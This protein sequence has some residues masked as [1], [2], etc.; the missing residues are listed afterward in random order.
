MLGVKFTETMRGTFKRPGEAAERAIEFTITARGSALRPRF[1]AD[2]TLSAE[3]IATRRP[4]HGQLILRPILG[5]TLR[6]ELEFT[7][8]DGRPYGFAGQKDLELLRLRKTMTTLPGQIR[9][10]DG[11]VVGEVVVKFDLSS[12]L[13]GF[14]GSFRPA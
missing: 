4:A 11:H 3:G 10:R 9:D 12:D 7:G 8:D 2:G 14:L 13:L 6:Y 1:A 5:R